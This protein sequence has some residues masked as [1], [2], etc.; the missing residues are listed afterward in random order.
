MMSGRRGSIA[1][2]V[3]QG[4]I[5][6]LLQ[7][8]E[9]ELISEDAAGD[10][11][12]PTTL[13]REK[14]GVV[15]NTVLNATAA[16]PRTRTLQY[17]YVRQVGKGRFGPVYKATTAPDNKKYPG[18]VVAVKVISRSDGGAHVVER[19][20]R[21]LS[22]LQELTRHPHPNVVRLL[23]HQEDEETGELQIVMEYMCW[24]LKH[25]LASMPSDKRLP[26]YK[27]K[28]Y[29]YQLCRALSHIHGHHICH[30]DLKPSN[31]LLDPSTD[32]I[33]V[34]DFGESKKMTVDGGRSA[35]YIAQRIYRAPEVILDNG[36]YNH[37][38]DIWALGCIVYETLTSKVL[39]DGKNQPDQLVQIFKIRG[40]PSD[41]IRPAPPRPAPPRPTPPHPT[42]PSIPALLLFLHSCSMSFRRPAHQH[43]RV[44]G[45][46][47][48]A[49]L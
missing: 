44:H 17:I 39:F 40:T 42:P 49:I 15:R 13:R 2:T 37:K 35:T 34:A 12:T 9:D 18:A 29:A 11:K 48:A 14:L 25:A 16:T 47:H 30:R 26:R 3:I 23:D 10:A 22:L 46:M 32:L 31:I 5:S 28:L 20:A 36:L 38:V 24:T 27:A 45:L 7:N 8:P 43:A 1:N 4:A 41:V 33:K 6:A 21:E 19:G